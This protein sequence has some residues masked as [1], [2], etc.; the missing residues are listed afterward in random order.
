MTES[1]T[2][3]VLC[4]QKFDIGTR[5]VLW[6]EPNGL[7]GYDTSKHVTEY[8]DRKTGKTQRIVVEG[9]RYSDRNKLFKI[10]ELPQL[11]KKITQFFLHHSGLYH[12]QDTFEVLHNQRR[13]SVHFILDDDGTIYQ[14][15]DLKEKAWHG[16]RNNSISVGIEIDS[17]ANAS[18]RP[19]AYDKT[20]QLKYRVGPRDIRKDKVQGQWINGFEYSEAQYKAL[21]SLAIKLVDIFPS[22]KL[23]F[24]RDKN[25]FIAQ[26]AVSKPLNHSGFICHYNTNKGK[27]D[28][29]S[30]DH[31]RFLNGVKLRMPNHPRC[32]R[33]FDNW[34]RRQWTLL[35]LD[36]DCGQMD[37]RFGP[38]T[39]S[40]LM[41]FQADYGL[42]VDGIWGKNTH[43][44]MESVLNEKERS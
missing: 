30:F 14:T 44:A 42:V 21:I 3:I 27:I 11:Q 12:A 40:A 13:L 26:A 41:K 32:F 38:K 4:G 1:N 39:K 16:G 33:D 31:Y 10:K 35:K 5:V 2:N 22:I 9:K 6:N 18:V 7:N 36:Y 23:D 20:H 25:G 17:R 24:P 37:G 15:L 34:E 19:Y 28:P 8:E 43:K 29:I